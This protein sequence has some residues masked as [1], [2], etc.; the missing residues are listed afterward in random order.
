MIFDIR[1]MVVVFVLLNDGIDDG[2]LLLDALIKTLRRTAMGMCVL[3]GRT[4]I[5]CRAFE[6]FSK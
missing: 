3:C 5:L 6:L 2:P 1:S 4:D